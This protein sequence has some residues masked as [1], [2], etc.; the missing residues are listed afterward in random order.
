MS[1]Q[2]V[3]ADVARDVMLECLDE[4][5][6]SHRIETVLGYHRPDPFAVSMTFLAAD[7]PLTWTFGRD[8]LL[9]GLH[10]PAGAGDVHVA[11]AVAHDGRAVVHVTLS[12][13][14]GELLLAADA[15]Q[16]SDFLDDTLALVPSGLESVNLDVDDLIAQLLG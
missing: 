15:H 11:P 9:A 12:S 7:E 13:P 3:V 16:V 10:E 4:S 8:L 5:G 1:Q 6:N 14:D 2:P